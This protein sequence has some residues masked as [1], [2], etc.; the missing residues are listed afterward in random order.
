MAAS[1]NCIQY[2]NISVKD[3][4]LYPI[5]KEPRQ[6]PVDVYVVNTFTLEQKELI[7]KSM[8][9]WN[10]VTKGKV[11]TNLIF[12]Y[13][14]ERP[15]TR[16][17]YEFYSKNTIWKFRHDDPV[18]LPLQLRHGFFDG[19][20]IGNFIL[21]SESESNKDYFN[22]I[23]LHEFGH[24][25]GLEHLKDEYKGLMHIGGNKGQFTRY[26]LIQFDSIYGTKLYQ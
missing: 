5:E 15:F 6:F 21:Y 13:E 19:V 23:L 12:D 26:D 9:L 20:C 4:T 11:V 22:I 1:Y 17:N 16:D 8:K 25:L 7:S 18:I 14:P 10:T 3:I 2:E 24:F